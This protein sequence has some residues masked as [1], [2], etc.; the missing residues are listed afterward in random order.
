MTWAIVLFLAALQG[1]AEFLPISSSGHLRI[2]EVVLG[3]GDMPVLFD[4]MLHLG[5]LCAVIIVYR[6]LLAR[7]LWATLRGLTRPREA[8]LGDPDFRL[9]AHVMLAM[10]PTIGLVVVLRTFAETWAA[11]LARVGAT[12]CVT[13]L[14]LIAL[15][16]RVRAM[17]RA[18]ELARPSDKTSDATASAPRTLAQMTWRDALAI[19]T[20]QGLSATFRGLSRS[21]ST[22]TTGVYVGLDQEAAASF[23]FMVSIPAILGALVFA[24]RKFDGQSDVVAYGLIGAVVAAIV[25]YFA[26]RWLLQMLGRGRLYLFAG[27]CAAVGVFAIVWRFT[28]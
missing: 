23:S 3:L 13:A 2:S 26:L 15:Q 25:G 21:G 7:T 22:I 1:L 11:D 27:W 6:S 10:V 28:H 17:R 24:L 16:L 19:G 20:A 14:V 18:R 8:Y 5:T 4:V 12:L 9:A